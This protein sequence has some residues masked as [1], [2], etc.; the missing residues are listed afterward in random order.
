MV[1][2]SVVSTVKGSAVS[3]LCIFSH[4]CLT[5]FSPD[6]I[7]TSPGTLADALTR[8]LSPA[9]WCVQQYAWTEGQEHWTELIQT[10]QDWTTGLA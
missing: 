1:L 4:M 9:I 6:S 8:S 3:G 5:L 7:I 10:G 2:E